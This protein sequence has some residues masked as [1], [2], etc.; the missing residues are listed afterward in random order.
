MEF[1]VHI[2][3]ERLRVQVENG[4]CLVDGDLVEVELTPGNGTPIRSASAE[5]RS[6]RIRPQHE[7]RGRWRLEV[8]GDQ[9]T[10]EVLD[11][12]QEAIR[13]ARRASGVGSGPPP[14]KAP[15]PGLV[16]RVEV[17]EG[18]EV[19]AGQGVVI[20]EA[21]KMENELR[22]AGPA[23]VRSIMAQEGA[24]VEKDQVL[25]EFEPLEAT[26]SSEEGAEE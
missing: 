19:K 25:V 9:H 17:S 21:M 16:V 10:V 26:D 5:G 24:A 15:M 14:L 18:D 6:L 2:D 12:G 1:F 13:Q 3:G 7:G 20:V 4:R 22:A 8:E 11:L 23:R